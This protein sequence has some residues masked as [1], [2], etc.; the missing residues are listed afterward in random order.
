MIKLILMFP[1]AFGLVSRHCFTGELNRA[2]LS[3]SFIGVDKG[4]L[5]L[6]EVPSD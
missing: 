4:N 1:S 3:K 5:V 6:Y 2:T